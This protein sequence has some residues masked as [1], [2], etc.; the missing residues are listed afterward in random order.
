MRTIS[1]AFALALLFSTAQ[2]AEIGRAQLNG[3]T[4][5]VDGSGS[6]T[7]ADAAAAPSA[8]SCN[9]GKLVSSRKIDFSLCVKSPW[10]VDAAASDSF[11]I[12]LKDNADEIYS[13]I[14]TE[15]TN[16]PEKAL[17]E[18]IISN[19]A[20]GTG[21]RVED[22]PVVKREKLMLNNVEWNYVEYDVNFNGIQLRFANYYKSLGEGGAVQ[23]VFWCGRNFFEKV[24]PA[25]A[26]IAGSVSLVAVK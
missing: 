15:R 17:A 12:S 10:T 1:W 8:L 6:W 22:I 2:A 3:R 13:G 16:I 9:D 23:M 26:E 14:I 5:I 20:T 21:V 24:Q 7:Y 4:I 18:A 25:I 11:E 19:A